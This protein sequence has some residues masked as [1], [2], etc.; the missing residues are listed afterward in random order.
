MQEKIF[1]VPISSI[2]NQFWANVLKYLFLVK[3][4]HNGETCHVADFSPPKLQSNALNN[5]SQS[6]LDLSAAC[7]YQS[8]YELAAV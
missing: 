2:H 3:T 8:F 6:N 7:H 5:Y 1:L 4:F